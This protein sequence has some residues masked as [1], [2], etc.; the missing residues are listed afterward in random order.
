MKGGQLQR[1]VGVLIVST[2]IITTH[3][4]NIT[5]C[6][7]SIPGSCKHRSIVC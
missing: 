1:V 3:W 6:V 5:V 7:L 2:V 4:L